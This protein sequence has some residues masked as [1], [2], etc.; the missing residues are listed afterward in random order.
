MGDFINPFSACFLP[1]PIECDTLSPQCKVIIVL[2]CES[3]R[4]ALRGLKLKLTAK[5]RNKKLI[6]TL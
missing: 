6:I 4:Q 5:Q 3:L 1:T 2:F